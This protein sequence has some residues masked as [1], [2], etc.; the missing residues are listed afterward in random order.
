MSQWW[1]FLYMFAVGCI[2]ESMN[3]VMISGEAADELITRMQEHACT[4]TKPELAR[5]HRAGLL[6]R[7]ERHSL[8]RGRGMVSVYPPGTADQLHAL[9]LF[10][11]SEKRLPYVAWCL[12]WAGYDVPIPYAPQFL[13]QATATWHR[14]IGDLH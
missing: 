7:R 9:C 11:R 4:V 8:G 10:H 12:W 3:E 6:P 2:I 1:H 14:P 5:W 13:E